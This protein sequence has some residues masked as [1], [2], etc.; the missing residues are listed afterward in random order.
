MVYCVLVLVHR[1]LRCIHGVLHTHAYVGTYVCMYCAM[2]SCRGGWMYVFLYCICMYILMYVRISVAG[3]IG[4]AI[5]Y[6]P[7]IGIV[8]HIGISGGYPYRFFI[9]FFFFLLRCIFQASSIQSD[10]FTTSPLVVLSYI[11]IQSDLFTTSHL[12]LGSAPIH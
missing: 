1:T 7:I 4:S 8:M 2:L 5:G 6:R 12:K 9:I 10:L 11:S 3:I